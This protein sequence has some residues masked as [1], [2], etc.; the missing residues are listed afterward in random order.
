MDSEPCVRFLMKLL[1]AQSSQPVVKKGLGAIGSRLAAF[2]KATVPRSGTS[3]VGVDRGAAVVTKVR[4]L[5]KSLQ[6]HGTGR[7]SLS[8]ENGILQGEEISSKWLALLTLEKACIST[9]V[10]EG[11][12]R[13]NPSFSTLSRFPYNFAILMSVVNRQSGRM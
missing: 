13:S 3:V 10:L 11:G 9:V 8:D 12:I 6:E 5:F 7:G 1:G 4:E 2:A